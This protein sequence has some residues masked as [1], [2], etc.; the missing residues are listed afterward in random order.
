M[1]HR[2]RLAFAFGG[3]AATS[4]AL[5]LAAC[6]T[7]NGFSPLP[8]TGLDSGGGTGS[9]RDSST[10]RDTGPTPGEEEE[11]DAAIDPNADCSKVPKLRSQTGV[12]CFRGIETDDA[13]V[14]GAGRTCCS[15]VKNNRTFT[16]KCVDRGEACD[17]ES[18]A[19]AGLE[20]G[21]EWHC[22]ESSHCESDQACCVIKG[23]MG[24][25]KA[26]VDT[27][28]FPG[29]GT[30]FNNSDKAFVGGSRCKTTCAADEV[31]LCAKDEDCTGGA[32]CKFFKIANRNSG[33]C[34]K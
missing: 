2:T 33:T 1:T 18:F 20:D 22:T 28:E 3:A 7:D 25:P 32:K 6:S 5:V 13:G 26:T 16:S 17:F 23:D 10:R 12:Y 34:I 9:T 4:I 11:E 15:D 21:R 19:D 14:C 8:T 24:A 30:Y 31:R 29:C 27:K